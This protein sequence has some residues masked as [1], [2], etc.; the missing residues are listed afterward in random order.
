MKYFSLQRLHSK[1]RNLDKFDFLDEHST[2]IESFSPNC[3][4]SSQEKVKDSGSST[5]SSHLT[6][7]LFL[8]GFSSQRVKSSISKNYSSSVSTLVT[9]RKSKLFDFFDVCLNSKFLLTK[10]VLDKS[11]DYSKFNFK[12]NLITDD[13]L[14]LNNTFKLLIDREIKVFLLHKSPFILTRYFN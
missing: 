3:L 2:I 11:I 14:L 10:T 1:N 7:R 5:N 13:T 4:L 8:E 6:T 9:L 12:L